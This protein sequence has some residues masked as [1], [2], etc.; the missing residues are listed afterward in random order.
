MEI[1]L[2]YTIDSG[3]GYN[4]WGLHEASWGNQIIQRYGISFSVF[5]NLT[6]STNIGRNSN[7]TQV[8]NDRWVTEDTNIGDTA[9]AAGWYLSIGKA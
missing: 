1:Y 2:K 8:Y 7:G 9:K 5:Y 6:V 4:Q 3:K